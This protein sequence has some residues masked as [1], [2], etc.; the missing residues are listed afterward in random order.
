[1][2]RIN[3]RPWSQVFVDG[4]L[5]GNTPIM[6]VPLQAGEHQV[7]LVNAALNVRKTIQVKIKPDDVV[8]KIVLLVD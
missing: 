8:T 5:I 4:R 7:E 2:M 6:G 1:M 3:S